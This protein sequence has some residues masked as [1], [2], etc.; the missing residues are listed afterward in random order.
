MAVNGQTDQGTGDREKEEGDKETEA[1]KRG[2]DLT[3]LLRKNHVHLINFK[4][5]AMLVVFSVEHNIITDGVIG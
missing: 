5:S 4:F 2:R 1:T 3:N